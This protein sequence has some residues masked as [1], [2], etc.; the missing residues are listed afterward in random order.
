MTL[1][2]SRS[3]IETYQDCPRYRFNNYHLLGKG[4]VPVAKSIPLVTGSAV[5]RG[6]EHLLN[7]V[8][9]G[10]E[11]DIE[12][13]V[14]LAVEQ[15]RKDCEA[16]GFRGKGVDTD[17]QQLFTFEEQ[18][19][20]TEALIRAWAIVELPNI[21]AR[22]KVVAVEREIEPLDLASEVKFMARVDAEFQ[23]VGSGDY[24]N[25]SLKTMKTW[26]ERSENSYKS[27]LQ[28]VTE[29]WAVEEDAKRADNTIDGIIA[30]LEELTK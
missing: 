5:H 22:Y 26:N 24:F 10:Q 30:N 1:Y 12:V 21:V 27:D 14:Q 3:E 15:Y 29:I 7:R 6:V 9:I 16:T 2:T 18:K 23:E 19:A 13:A 17:R 20:L 28:G 8:R 25:Y 11:V 4:V